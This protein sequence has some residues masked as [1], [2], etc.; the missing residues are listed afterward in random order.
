VIA[1]AFIA[2]AFTGAETATALVVTVV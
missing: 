1:A 2:E